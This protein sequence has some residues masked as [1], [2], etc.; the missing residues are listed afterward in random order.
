MKKKSGLIAGIVILI[1]LCIGAGVL[2]QNMKPAASEGEK[3][4]T[5]TV[6]HGDQTENV[7]EFDTDA[8]YLGEVLESERMIPNN[9]GGVSQKA[10][11]RSTL[12]QIRHQFLTEMHLSLH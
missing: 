4:I 6:I 9:N 8:K 11:N 7:F 1:L 10:E 2:Y 3:H 12:P 5:V